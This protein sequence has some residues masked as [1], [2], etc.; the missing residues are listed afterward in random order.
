MKNDITK[1]IGAGYKEGYNKGYSKGID[2][3]VTLYMTI[4]Y[5]L[6]VDVYKFTPDKLQEL[7]EHMEKCG[8]YLD[9]GAISYE[10]LIE[11]LNKHGVDAMSFEEITKLKLKGE[12]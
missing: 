6:L 10:D 9:S 1:M 4:T 5:N 7:R 11:S 12:K 2:D 8:K 3:G